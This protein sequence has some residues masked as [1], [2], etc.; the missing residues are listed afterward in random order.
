MKLLS[1]L[2]SVGSGRAVA[3]AYTLS[4]TAGTALAFAATVVL[5][6]L[7]YIHCRNCPVHD[8][9]AARVLDRDQT[10]DSSI[11]REGMIG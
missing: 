7:G 11:E 5:P 8:A 2:N 4:T 10:A 6:L 9:A 3:L 1:G